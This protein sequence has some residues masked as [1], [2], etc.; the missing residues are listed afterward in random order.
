MKTYPRVVDIGFTGTRDGMTH[1]QAKLFSD[2]MGETLTLYAQMTQFRF[3]FGVCKGA[4]HQA[5]WIAK[6]LG[7]YII[8]HPPIDTSQMCA[9]DVCDELMPPEAYLKRNKSIV[10]AS[11]QMIATPK[12]ATEKLRSGTWATIRYATASRKKLTIMF[13]NGDRHIKN[14]IA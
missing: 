10:A 8:G 5:A 3:R 7:Y 2:L 11:L 6:G 14:E 1:A 4:D 13:P 9:I 12:E